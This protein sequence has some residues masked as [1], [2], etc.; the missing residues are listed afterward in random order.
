MMTPPARPIFPDS[1]PGIPAYII[2]CC[3][4]LRGRELAEA[5]EAQFRKLIDIVR[6]ECVEDHGFEAPFS[7]HVTDATGYVFSAAF[8]KGAE[9]ARPELYGIK[10]P[11]DLNGRLE[12]HDLVFPLSVFASDHEGRTHRTDLQR[13]Q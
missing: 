2:V 1:T 11:E 7:I 12:D 3:Y 9:R 6:W 4:T 8:V 10:A 13:I 5:L